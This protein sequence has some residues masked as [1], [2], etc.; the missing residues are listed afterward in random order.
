[1][2]LKKGDLV[3]FVST[4]NGVVIKSLDLAANDL[5]DTLAKSLGTRG[6]KLENVLTRSQNV[7]ADILVKEFKL[8]PDERKILFQA[9]QLKA[10][11]A[12]EAIRAAESTPTSS[13]LSDED[14]EREIQE[15]RKHLRHADRA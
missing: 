14:I 1:L 15:S 9:L 6:I 11:S 2:N 3:T 12:V 4:E 10:Q 8:K 7:S 5:L 13:E